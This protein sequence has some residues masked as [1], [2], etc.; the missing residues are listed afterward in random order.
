MISALP[1]P[2]LHP[3]ADEPP[4]F[5][6]PN[7]A[8]DQVLCEVVMKYVT[9]TY[10]YPYLLLQQPFWEPWRKIDR[11]WRGRFDIQDATPIAV[12]TTALKEN[13]PWLG[14]GT[15]ANGQSVMFFR[16]NHA[17]TD[18]GEQMSFEQG[19]PI[20]AEVPEEV[21]EDDFYRP[22]E[23]SVIAANSIFRQDA[24]AYSL[25][26]QWRKNFG[27]F[28]KYGTAWAMKD[29]QKSI[30]S[31]KIRFPVSTPE[32]VQQIQLEHPDAPVQLEQSADGAL[33]VAERKEVR[34]HTIFRHLRIDDV[35]IDPL[36][37]CDPVDRQPCPIVREHVTAMDLE[38][39]PY[40]PDDNPF[41]YLNIELAVDQEKGH[42][43]LTEQSEKPLQDQLRTR[44]HISDS[45]TL[46]KEQMRFHQKW[47]AYPWLRIGPEGD[48]DIGE[49]CLCPTCKGAKRVQQ[50][51]P[52][53]GIT[54][55]DCPSCQG[56]GRIRV[57]AKRYVVVF[58]GAP[59]MRT[60][61]LRIQELPEGMGVPL[62]YAADLVEDDSCAIP[63][64]TS[65]ISLIAIEQ[66]TRAETQFIR[67]KD[68]VIDRGWKVKWDSPASDI[69]NLNKPGIKIPFEND[70]GEVQRIEPNTYDE[71]ATLIPFIQ[72]CDDQIQSIKGATDTLLG[73]LASGRR[74]AMEIGQ[75]TE[76]AKN[77]L[78][79]LV[80]RYNRRMMGGWGEATIKNLETFGDRDYITRRT[81]RPW[82]GKVRIVTSAGSDFIKKMAMAN[83]L[84]WWLQAIPTLPQL[85]PILP[86][87]ANK[88][89]KISGITG[90][91]IPDGGVRKA[92]NDAMIIITQILGDGLPIP[93]TPSDP[94]QLYIDMFTA[95]IKDPYW[96]KFPQNIQLMGQ[97]IMMQQQMLD[98]Q[99][100]MQMR[101][102]AQEAAMQQAAQPPDQKQG[103]KP[104]GPS[105]VKPTPGGAQQAAQ[106]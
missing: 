12:S 8:T 28:V 40:H 82:F 49:G 23:Q 29:F 14:D 17:I 2:E 18:I 94:H 38:Q 7:L 100:E 51:D 1:D 95:A 96:Q 5:I 88:L 105:G 53:G 10:W 59:R 61:C 74:S 87:L 11:A 93:A 54:E 30:G 16:Q 4:I 13:L 3:S 57:P 64:S 97:R 32:Q 58:Y 39:Y 45:I 6:G 71:S 102:Q 55:V 65:E 78:V 24:E 80:D 66:A 84:R 62:L 99:M 34:L 73:M 67:S 44:Y 101:M 86:Q 98:Q 33:A 25:R 31:V 75:A 56:S 76:A 89:L 26:D 43:A 77:P 106:G 70:P 22:T 79:L 19:I 104:P 35:F 83:D 69:Q 21:D 81:G 63:M 46:T 9:E 68:M 15:S 85:A 52:F 72:R 90:I 20:R 37:S 60:T 50:A 42:Y 103:N 27:G 47:T 36:I 92:T 91:V 41:G 48:L